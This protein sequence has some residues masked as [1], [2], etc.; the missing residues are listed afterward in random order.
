[1]SRI[2]NYNQAKKEYK[3]K[4]KVQWSAFLPYWMQR[5]REDIPNIR[6]GKLILISELKGLSVEQAK[7][8]VNDAVNRHLNYLTQTQVYMM[9]VELMVDCQGDKDEIAK[10]I[11][12]HC[13]MITNK[14]DNG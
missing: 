7:G 8:M 4:N 6:K 11:Y 10:E 9:L 13:D 1:M 2:G 12:D 3:A 5:K 14:W